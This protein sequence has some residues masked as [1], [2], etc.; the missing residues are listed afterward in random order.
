[1]ITKIE[2]L[3]LNKKFVSKIGEAETHLYF[4]EKAIEVLD[5]IGTLGFITPNTWLSVIRQEN[6]RK[7]IMQE[8]E[9]KEITEL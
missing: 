5:Q 4:I 9:I 3:Y 1:M 7:F 6:I 2:K 8:T